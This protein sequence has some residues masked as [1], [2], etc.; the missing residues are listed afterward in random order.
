MHEPKYQLY[1]LE[2]DPSQNN[3]LYNKETAIAE[4]LKNKLHQIRSGK[5]TRRVTAVTTHSQRQQQRH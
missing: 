5:R 4:R 2:A 1:D 3:N